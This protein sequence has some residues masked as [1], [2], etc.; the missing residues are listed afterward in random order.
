MSLN[1]MPM[2][3]KLTRSQQPAAIAALAQAFLADPIMQ[4][5]YAVEPESRLRGLHWLSQLMVRY[6]QPYDQVYIATT[7]SNPDRVQGCAV[8]LPPSAY[9]LNIWRLLWLGFYQFPLHV[10]RDR[11]GEFFELFEHT[12][13]CHKEAMTEPHWYLAMLGVSP[14]FQG[15]GVGGT[16]LQPVLNAANRDRVPCYL[17]TSTE[18]G[19]RFY[20]RLGFE[21][22]RVEQR[23]PE[24]PTFWT[25]RRNPA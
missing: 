15:Q 5:F 1:V 13:Q 11:I 24:A 14:A 6:S 7:E 21:I 20:Q 23:T 8:W 4:Y 3:Q 2:S 19:V 17:E 9:P 25:M 12:E 22:L 10:R 16:L 18:G